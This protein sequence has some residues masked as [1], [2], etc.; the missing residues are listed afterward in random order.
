MH[1]K[2]PEKNCPIVTTLA[3]VD[4]SSLCGCRLLDKDSMSKIYVRNLLKSETKVT[5][6]IITYIN[7]DKAMSLMIVQLLLW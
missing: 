4:T 3:I 2:T 5:P 6:K 7:V 1:I